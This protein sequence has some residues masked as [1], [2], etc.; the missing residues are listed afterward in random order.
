[1]VVER[2]G[3]RHQRSPVTLTLTREP[4]AMG[5]GASLFLLAVGAVLAFAVDV[6]SKGFDLNTIGVILMIVGGLGIVLSMIFWSSWGGF[7]HRDEVVVD[8]D[9]APRRRVI[10]EV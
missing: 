1:M 8:R 4:I 7:G 9:R 6:Q 10:E 2:G 5:I 3:E